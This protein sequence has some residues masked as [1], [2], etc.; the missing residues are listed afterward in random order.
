LSQEVSPRHGPLLGLH[1]SRPSREFSGAHK[2]LGY[3]NG[4]RMKTAESC[5]RPECQPA[6]GT[7]AGI[8]QSRAQRNRQRWEGS[9]NRGLQTSEQ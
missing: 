7:I 4:W 1:F 2:E 9:L 5:E 8:P 3:E 6:S